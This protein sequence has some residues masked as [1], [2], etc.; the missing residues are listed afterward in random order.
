M[1]AFQSELLKLCWHSSGRLSRNQIVLVLLD[2]VRLLLTTDI[3]AEKK[4][5][6][7]AID[8]SIDEACKNPVS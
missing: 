3:E 4:L 6:Q 1:N 8:Q 2:V 7:D 5:A